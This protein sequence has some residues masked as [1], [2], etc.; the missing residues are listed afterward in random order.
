MEES[1]FFT[2]FIIANISIAVGCVPLSRLVLTFFR[3]GQRLIPPEMVRRCCIRFGFRGS[4]EELTRTPTRLQNA[5][6]LL[7]SGVVN[8]VGAAII[9]W[10]L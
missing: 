2:V 8:A 1:P 9:R 5:G 6:V 10:F 4:E 7:A 3:W